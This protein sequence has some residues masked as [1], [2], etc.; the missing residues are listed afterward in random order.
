M[1]LVWIGTKEADDRRTWHLGSGVRGESTLDGGDCIP[2]N[3][4]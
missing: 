2:I 3:E 4:V 1:T